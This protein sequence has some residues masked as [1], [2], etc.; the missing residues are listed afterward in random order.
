MDEENQKQQSQFDDYDDAEP[1]SRTNISHWHLVRD[2]ALLTPLVL[3]HVWKEGTGT[4]SDPYL[5]D[6]LPPSS[7]NNSNDEIDIRNPLN[8]PLLT[9]WFIAFLN[10][11][12][13]LALTFAS[14]AYTSSLPD[15][16]RRLNIAPETAFLGTSLFVLGFAL[17]PLVWAPLSE[18]FGRR[19]VFLITY[20]L[21][22]ALNIAAALPDNILL[23]VTAR[24]LG[25]ML[26]AS[27]LVNSS[28][29]TADLFSLKDR[30]KVNAYFAAAPFLG[31]VLGPIVGGFL[32]QGA[33]GWKGV[34]GVITILTAGVWIVYFF[35]V[36][37]TYAPVLLRLRARRLTQRSNSQYHYQSRLDKAG[38]G[39]KTVTQMLRIAMVRPFR[40]LFSETIVLVLSIYMAI[41]F[42]AMYLMFAAFPIVFQSP[43]GYNFGPGVG[44]LAF[45]GIGGGMIFALIYMLFANKQY[46]R[47]AQASPGGK[48]PPETRLFP[49]RLGA[50]MAPAGLVIFA[51]TNSPEFHFLIPILGTVPFGF[52][53][54]VIF[55]SLLG[56]LVDTYT[57]YAASAIA[58]A[59]AVRSVFGA[60]FPLFT[61]TM[62]AK[63]GVH[64]GAGVPALLA[65][66]CLPFPFLFVVYGQRIREKAK[67]ATEARN[68]AMKMAAAAAAKTKEGNGDE[69]KPLPAE[70]KETAFIQDTK[71]RPLS[72][73]H[74]PTAEGE[75]QCYGRFCLGCSV[76]E[77]N[78]LV[79]RNVNLYE[80]KDWALT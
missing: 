60:V 34:G 3:S 13:T 38:G 37:E 29:G 59:T 51:V 63:L 25:G 20:G 67:F 47:I 77:D 58:A 50:V 1:S 52:G 62:F 12:A 79:C 36:P 5:V 39:P 17:G 30:G 6:F 73:A 27:A 4:S 80:K 69:K 48:A 2:A 8:L 9:R 22:V 61:R 54:V 64:F 44:G 10:A 55:I 75:W 23:I 24:G 21:F 76:D 26:G 7:S 11:F 70:E 57:V 28:G 56:Y 40:L 35:V 71:E 33:G 66:L 65:A 78:F 43:Q 45:L 41:I 49:A 72:E 18:S 74:G 32:S 46:V 31:P 68:I 14:S 53:M 16:Q 15:L 19:P 42:G